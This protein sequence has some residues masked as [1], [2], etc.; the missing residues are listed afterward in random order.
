MNEDRVL[1]SAQDANREL[2]ELLREK[3]RALYTRSD[4]VP[5]YRDDR[6][7]IDRVGELREEADALMA[8]ADKLDPPLADP[9]ALPSTA[10]RQETP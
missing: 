5:L 10:T 3:A 7:G 8:R 2:A 6:R 1:P 4:N 9:R